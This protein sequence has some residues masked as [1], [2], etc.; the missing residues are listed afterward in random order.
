MI[1]DTGNDLNSNI[2]LDIILIAIW[3]VWK[4]LKAIERDCKILRSNQN[5]FHCLKNESVSFEYV[6]GKRLYLHRLLRGQ[7]LVRNRIKDVKIAR[8]KKRLGLPH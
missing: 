5:H 8:Q 2:I 3:H 1:V 6:I 7:I 4:L